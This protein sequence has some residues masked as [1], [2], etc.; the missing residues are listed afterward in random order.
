MLKAAHVLGQL[1]YGGFFAYNGVNH[2]QH[3]ETMAQYAD[4]KGVPSPQTAVLGSGALLLLGGLSVLTG[5]KPRAGLAMI[6]AFLIGATPAMHAFWTIADPQQRM[7]EQVNFLKNLALL[8]SVLML[9]R[10]EGRES[11]GSRRRPSS[12]AAY[13]P[14]SAGYL[15]EPAM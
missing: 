6:A 2:F 1:I 4:S 13:L 12:P 7:G 11:F 5:Y 14:K 10:A 3:Q 8:G 9:M 15:P